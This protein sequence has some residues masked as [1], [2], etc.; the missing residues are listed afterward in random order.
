MSARSEYRASDGVTR[1]AYSYIDNQGLIQTAEYEAGKDLGFRIRATNL[2]EAPLPVM[3]TLEVREARERHLKLLSEAEMRED[4]SR[5]DESMSEVVE[6][7][8][9]EEPTMMMMEEKAGAPT[10]I[11]S[12]IAEMPEGKFMLI[13][14]MVGRLI[15]CK[16]VLVIGAAISW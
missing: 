6:A 10:M 4:K 16:S 2:P 13:G 7:K 1:G 15:R 3:E 12:K 11:E 5:M 9:S 8:K 14:F